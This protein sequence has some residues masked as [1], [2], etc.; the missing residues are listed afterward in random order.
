MSTHPTLLVFA[1]P[2]GSGKS[3]VTKSYQIVGAYINADEIQ[4]AG[5]YTDLEAAV[6]ATE[7]RE[8]LLK[9]RIDFTFETVLST[10]RNIDLMDRAR[11]A[12]Y[13]VMC[14]FIVTTHHSINVRRDKRRG[15]LGGHY[16]GEETVVRRYGRVMKL[17]PD[18][19]KVCDRLLIYDN[20]KDRPNGKSELIVELDNGTIIIHPSSMWSEKMITQLLSGE[21]KPDED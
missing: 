12:G 2:N 14:I 6:I 8:H 19:L 21:Y 4:R 1:G 5:N 16:V 15:E 3:T 10:T 17:I 20:S 18:L 7:T 9:Q 13:Y 11:K